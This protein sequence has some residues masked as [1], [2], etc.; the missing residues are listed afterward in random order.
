LRLVLAD[1][2]GAQAVQRVG[3]AGE[4]AGGVLVE[5]LGKGSTIRVKAL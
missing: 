3:H 5:A 4:Y 1:Q 2:A